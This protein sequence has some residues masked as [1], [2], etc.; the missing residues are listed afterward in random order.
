[1]E[2]E[3]G[4][5]TSRRW[6]E[7]R[8]LTLQR[9]NWGA[10]S[11]LWNDEQTDATLVQETGVTKTVEVREDDQVVQRTWHVPSRSECLSCHSRQA[12]FVLGM[13]TLQL[14]RQAE[15]GTAQISCFAGN[16]QNG[17]RPG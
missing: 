7:T 9:G 11:Y 15:I 3:A 2:T 17:R 10:Y 12:G 14:N 16:N 5:A 8:L 13:T 1:M 4:V 6:V